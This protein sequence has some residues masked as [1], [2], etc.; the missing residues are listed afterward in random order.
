MSKT[1]GQIG[2]ENLKKPEIQAAIQEEMAA[3]EKRTEITQ[4]MVLK[5][6]WQIA[7][8]DPEEKMEKLKLGDLTPLPSLATLMPRPRAF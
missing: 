2:E 8:A 7:N 4:D 6:W 5:R 1:A 3:R